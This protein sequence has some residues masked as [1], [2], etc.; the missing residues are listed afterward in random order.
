MVDEYIVN[1]ACDS[2]SE[3]EEEE[4]ENGRERKKM[5][6]T[7]VFYFKICNFVIFNFVHLFVFGSGPC[8]IIIYHPKGHL[9]FKFSY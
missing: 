3:E 1:I 8:N 7:R 4:E 5:K 6:T 2:T 9:N